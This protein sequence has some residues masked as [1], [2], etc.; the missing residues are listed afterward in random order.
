MDSRPTQE[1]QRDLMQILACVERFKRRSRGG[2]CEIF[3]E[4]GRE[5]GEGKISFCRPLLV[6][7]SIGLPCR[8][9]ESHL[10]LAEELAEGHA[11][12]LGA[13]DCGAPAPLAFNQPLSPVG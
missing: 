7:P 12:E 1:G 5:L 8:R 4:G 3:S 11:Q 6:R 10:Q 2:W 9:E 13:G